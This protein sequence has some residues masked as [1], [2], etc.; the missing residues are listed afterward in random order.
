MK[1]PSIESSRLM[2]AANSTGKVRMAYHGNANAA[3][4]PAMTS[5][6]TSVAVSKP[7]PNSRPIG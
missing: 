5:N 6:P 7:N 2:P 1:Q 3:A 4:P